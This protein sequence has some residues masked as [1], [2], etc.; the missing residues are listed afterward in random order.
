MSKSV[1]S[2]MRGCIHKERPQNQRCDNCGEPL[3]YDCYIDAP[4]GEK[5][6]AITSRDQEIRVD[7]ARFCA[8]CYLKWE[9]RKGVRRIGGK[10]IFLTAP[11]VC[12]F[13]VER[14]FVGFILLFFSLV[15]APIALGLIFWYAS[16]EV[17]KTVYNR[18]HRAY[19]IL[20]QHASANLR[21]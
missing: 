3:C 6:T 10:L 12:A 20:E 5:V 21:K 17:V 11:F 1:L 14:N 9:E 4:V 15:L 18:Q 13:K 16:Y 2:D 8:A 7:Y 19:E